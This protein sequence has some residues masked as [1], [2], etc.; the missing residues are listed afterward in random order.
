MTVVVGLWQ[1]CVVI[2]IAVLQQKCDELLICN[3]VLLTTVMLFNISKRSTYVECAAT[4][5]CNSATI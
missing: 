4:H 1:Q 2:T 5:S 3:N